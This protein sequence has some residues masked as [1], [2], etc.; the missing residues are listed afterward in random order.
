M[1]PLLSELNNGSC[2]SSFAV[3]KRVSLIDGYQQ[4][5]LFFLLL[6][7]VFP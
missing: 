1:F 6:A 4:Q 5:Q 2:F 7:S 3:G